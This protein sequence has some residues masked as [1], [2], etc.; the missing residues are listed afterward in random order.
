MDSQLLQEM[1]SLADDWDAMATR[2]R[3]THPHI[4]KTY[5][6]GYTY[7]SADAFEASAK[8]LRSMMPDELGD[9]LL[10]C[11]S[12]ADAFRQNANQIEDAGYDLGY[13]NGKTDVYKNTASKLRS[14]IT[15]YKRVK[16]ETQA[17]EVLHS[18][19]NWVIDLDGIK[20][21]NRLIDVS[22]ALDC[23]LRF[24]K[25]GVTDE[26]FH[27]VDVVVSASSQMILERFVAEATK[28]T[29]FVNWSSI[30]Q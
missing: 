20:D 4:S 24:G 9:M 25:W 29:G 6:V 18:A 16:L 17:S 1:Q 10:H 21:L 23:E 7:G 2:L 14:L 28:R 19:S 3:Q 11:D 27:T 12:L 15:T 8:I 26:G 13:S 5:T 30:S 22:I